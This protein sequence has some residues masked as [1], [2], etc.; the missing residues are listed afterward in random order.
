MNTLGINIFKKLII[1][2][3]VLKKKVELKLWK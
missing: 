3:G 1:F 2:G